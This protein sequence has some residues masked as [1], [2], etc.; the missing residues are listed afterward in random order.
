MQIRP[1]A[2]EYNSYYATYV[3][4]VSDGN[5]IQILEQ[6]IE[7]TNLLLKDISDSEGLFRY[8]PTK[9]S[10]KR[11]NRPYCRYRTCYGVSL[12]IYR[13]RRDSRTSRL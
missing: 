11:S 10:I 7:E 1:K 5:I 9:W 13:S 2:S 8:A 3:N 12:V 4:L 6:E